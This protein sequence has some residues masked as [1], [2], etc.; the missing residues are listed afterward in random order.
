MRVLLFAMPD[1][2]WGFD[3]ICKI[4][5]LGIASIAGNLDDDVDVATVDLVLKKKNFRKYVRKFV[6]SF[7]PELVGLS[8]MTF[9]YT[10]AT[11]LAKQI[12]EADSTIKIAIG[13]Y[14]P[15]LT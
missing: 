13:G 10:T 11:K 4:P 9:Q 2:S 5:N 3:A 6:T 1:S 7:R 15:T 8:C 12:K 14:H